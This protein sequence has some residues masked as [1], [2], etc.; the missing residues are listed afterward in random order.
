MSYDNQMRNW[1]AEGFGPRIRRREFVAGALAMTL[2]QEA[3]AGR[4]PQAGEM[5]S[6]TEGEGR[7]L[8]FVH[9]WTMDHRDEARTYEPIFANRP[10]WRRHYL[11]LPGM[12][13]SP[14][15]E[16]IVN[17]DGMLEALLDFIQDRVEGT[18]AIAGTSTGAYLARGV[19]ARMGD[20][21]RG[22]ILRAPMIIPDDSRRDVDP[23]EPVLRDPSVLAE[24]SAGDRERLGELLVQTP[25]YAA[26]KRRKL[27]EAVAPAIA[28][29]DQAFLAAIRQQPSRYR[30]SFD[31]DAAIGRFDQPALIIT[32]RHDES[33]G[34]R[35]AWPLAR[36]FAR[37]TFVVL[38]RA[39]HGLPIDQQRVFT[40]LVNDW[41]DRLDEAS[42]FDPGARS[43]PG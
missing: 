12:G 42:A 24:M 23:I 11:D 35:D 26:A 17:L 9:G 18:F 33:V 22:A 14:R 19:I 38:D 3:R 28:A 39:E 21:V 15:R 8:I 16:N 29:A 4:A 31:P 10:G 2:A 27:D 37:S 30:L 34:Y 41:L 6:R 20:R 36:V 25:S 5:W 43:R 40:A 13:R 1:P 7:D 32:G